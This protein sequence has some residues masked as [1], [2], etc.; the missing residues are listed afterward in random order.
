MYLRSS[1]LLENSCSLI[2]QKKISAL[3]A[4]Q[5]S[6][7]NTVN[8]E[9]Y[10]L[11]GTK[12]NSMCQHV[13][14]LKVSLL[15]RNKKREQNFDCFHIC[16]ISSAS[17]F[18]LPIHDTISQTQQQSIEQPKPKSIIDLIHSTKQANRIIIWYQYNINGK[19]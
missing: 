18:A 6:I 9:C 10:L 2:G 5:C 1:H 11:F 12:L 7:I 4:N 15:S 16:T 17:N 8:I 13:A 3:F 14:S 19:W